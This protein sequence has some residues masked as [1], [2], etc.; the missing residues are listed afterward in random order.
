MEVFFMIRFKTIIKQFG[1]KGEKTGWTYIDISSALAGKLKPDNKRSFR[2]KGKLDDHEIKAVA[3]VPMGGG[4]FIMALNASMRKAI[5][6]RKGASL[7]VELEID[8]KGPQLSADLME[9]LSDDPGAL[10][11]FNTLPRSHQQYFSNWIESAKTTP[12]KVK[13]ISMAVSALAKKW[14]YGEMVRAAKSKRDDLSK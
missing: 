11:F 14:G 7:S 2:V 9:C 10:S 3:L 8:E 12:T 4:D 5:G 13:R 1:E 6:K